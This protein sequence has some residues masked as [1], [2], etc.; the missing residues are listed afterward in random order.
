MDRI[1]IAGRA[2]AIAVAAAAGFPGTAMSHF[3]H[4]GTSVDDFPPIRPG[5]GTCHFVHNVTGEVTHV[6]CE[7]LVF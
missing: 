2:A 5:L 3:P 1:T 6:P 4:T 7:L